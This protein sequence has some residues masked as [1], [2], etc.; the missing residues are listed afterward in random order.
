[1]MDLYPL[2]TERGGCLGKKGER[3][4]YVKDIVILAFL[5][6]GKKQKSHLLILTFINKSCSMKG[7]RKEDA[8]IRF[9]SRAIGITKHKCRHDEDDDDDTDDSSCNKT[10]RNGEA[11]RFAVSPTSS[12]WNAREE[13][14]KNTERNGPVSR[15]EQRHR[16]HQISQTAFKGNCLP[17]Y[18][19]PV[20]SIQI[21]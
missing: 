13:S 17:I 6:L 9:G 2:Y 20:V 19:G 21:R 18:I 1:M 10:D 14:K 11:S 7:Q 12:V 8:T 4:E 3:E 15:G 16:R 5:L